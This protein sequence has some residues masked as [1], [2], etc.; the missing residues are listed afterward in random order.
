MAYGGGFGEV[1]NDHYFIHKGVVFSD[2]QPKP[3]YPEM[4]R[5]YQ[6]IGIAPDDLT[7]GTIKV[8]N[9]YAFITLEDFAGSWTMTEDGRASQTRQAA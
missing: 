3:H 8:R 6:W 1:P 4:K 5:A 2:R 7:A 9:K